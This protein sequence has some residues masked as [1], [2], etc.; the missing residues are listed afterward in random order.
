VDESRISVFI[1]AGTRLLRETLSRILG[2]KTD[3]EVVGA[4]AVCPQV[5]SQID[6]SSADILLMDSVAGE[7][8][9]PDFIREVHKELPDL[10]IMMIGME[11]EEELFVRYVRAGVVGYVLKEASAVDVTNAVRSVARGEAVCPPRLCLTLF[12]EVSRRQTE[13]PSF[14]VKMRF[15]LTRREQQLVPF[16]ARGMTNKE[17]AFQLNLSEQTVKNHIHRMMRKAGAEDRLSIVEH[18]L[19][20]TEH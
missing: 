5:I 1:I 17:I 6:S 19:T 4:E 16:I 10:K 20:E 8:S 12:H 11:E 14:Q 18:C 13:L 7:P 9:S 2:K 15:G 3:L